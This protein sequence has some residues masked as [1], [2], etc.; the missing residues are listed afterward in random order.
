M[1]DVLNPPNWY[2]FFAILISFC[3]VILAFVMTIGFVVKRDW[4]QNFI[5]PIGYQKS[6]YK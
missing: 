1:R 4:R 3:L 2:G 5:P 6:N